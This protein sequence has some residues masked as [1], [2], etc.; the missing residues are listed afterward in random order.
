MVGAVLAMVLCAWLGAVVNPAAPV[1]ARPASVAVDYEP[2]VAEHVQDDL[3]TALREG[4]RRG[5]IRLVPADSPPPIHRVHVHV[6]P[7][8]RGY[9]F[10]VQVDDE[11]GRAVAS[12]RRA[13]EL[14]G[15]V[16][17]A[18]M[19]ADLAATM[20]HA[21]L[22]RAPQP[23][24]VQLRTT[25]PE[26]RVRIDG[27]RRD[28]G[29]TSDEISLMP[30]PHVLDVDAAGYRP[31]HHEL[32]V[33]SG[34]RESVDVVLVP[35]TDRRPRPWLVAAAITGGLGIGA[36]AAGIGLWVVDGRRYEPS[37]RSD[38][39][40][41]NGRCARMY[42]TRPLGIVMTTLGAALT[43]TAVGLLITGVRARSKARDSREARL[44]PT[45]VTGFE[46][47]GSHHGRSSTRAH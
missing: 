39:V 29:S 16:E 4:L 6:E 7:T 20:A 5:G 30:G 15:V 38:G 47:L 23:G 3:D 37:C 8:R 46:A 14:C 13:C 24:V 11:A 10:D 33:S 12:S 35:L 28:R 34:V 27:I 18:E 43:G 25:P 21:L 42:T 1:N 2:T 44:R 22:E 32:T 36:T 40:D 31:A 26:A 17:A 41:T 19:L 45:R 9:A